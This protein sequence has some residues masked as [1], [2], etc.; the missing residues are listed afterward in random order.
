MKLT[1]EQTT[2]DLWDFSKHAFSKNNGVKIFGIAIL[3]IV[4]FNSFDDGV[5]IKNLLTLL[6]VVALFL[7]FTFIILRII[8]KNILNDEKN[9]KAL[10][11]ERDVHILDDKIIVQ[12]QS[13]RT[14]YEWEDIIKLSQSNL[15]YFLFIGAMQAIV[16]SKSAFKNSD[17]QKKFEEI[18]ASNIIQK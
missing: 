7:F 8:R 2:D 4:I 18:I 1:F 16:I 6:M 3:F 15:N 12:T 9:K 13:S 17:E 5:S 14:E 11:G 10:R